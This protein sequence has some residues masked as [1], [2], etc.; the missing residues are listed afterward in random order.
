MI[1]ADML[2]RFEVMDTR[3][4]TAEGIGVG[5]REVEVLGAY[6]GRVTV[7]PHKYDGPEGHYLVVPSRT[8]SAYA[9]VV[10]TDG[11]TVTLWRAGRRPEVDLVEGCS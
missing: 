8:D 2:V 1:V 3:A 5:S 7:E 10:E 9:F 11:R 4:R 6:R